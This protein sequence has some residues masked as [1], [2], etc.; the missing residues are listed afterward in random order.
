LR[1]KQI[2][3]TSGTDAGDNI[4]TSG[5]QFV[6]VESDVQ[7][8]LIK[9]AKNTA[10]IDTFGRKEK[11][12]Q[13]SEIKDPRQ[14]R[15]IANA[16]VAVF[17]NPLNM[18][19]VQINTIDETFFSFNPSETVV[20]NL[21]NQNISNATFKILQVDYSFTTASQLAEA[22]ITLRLGEIIKGATDILKD[23]IED[24]RK[25]KADAIGDVTTLP[26][27]IATTGS[28]GVKRQF[29]ISSRGI[30]SSFVLGHGGPTRF[31]GQLGSGFISTDTIGSALDFDASNDEIAL[32]SLTGFPSDN[33]ARTFAAWIYP[34]DIT[35][36]NKSMFSYGTPA[37]RSGCS[38][39]LNGSALKA[40]AFAHSSTDVSTVA[41]TQNVWNHIAFV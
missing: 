38:F 41:V 18:G 32:T 16:E 23:V 4:P 40:Q 22:H 6:F 14:A 24:I 28:M 34:H 39:D 11:V 29:F 25:L 35:T 19:T 13:N 1:Q 36:A 7:K 33:S 15:D 26:E 3:F 9:Q 31:L 21:P 37:T 30:G 2:I 27:L 10:S 20:V 8:T 5:N 12:I 17:G